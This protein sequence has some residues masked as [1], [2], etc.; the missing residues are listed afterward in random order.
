MKWVLV[1][2][3]WNGKEHEMPTKYDKI[4]DAEK[5]RRIFC[6]E[7]PRKGCLLREVKEEKKG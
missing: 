6:W 1:E 7:N 5:D 4:E 2:V 3:E